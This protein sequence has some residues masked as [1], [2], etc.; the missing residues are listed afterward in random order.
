MASN[1]RSAA[2][3]PS[4]SSVWRRVLLVLIVAVLL[5]GSVAAQAL[6]LTPVAIVLLVVALVACAPLVNPATGL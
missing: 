2:A 4:T 3:P 6:N 5:V 1:F